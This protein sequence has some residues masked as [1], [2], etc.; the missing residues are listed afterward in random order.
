MHRRS[1]NEKAH[2]QPR[3]RLFVGTIV[4][5]NWKWMYLTQKGQRAAYLMFLADYYLR[6]LTADRRWME[7]TDV[8]LLPMLHSFLV[9]PSLLS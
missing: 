1:D 3:R 5:M 9:S 8:M 7:A 4:V 6:V 2:H